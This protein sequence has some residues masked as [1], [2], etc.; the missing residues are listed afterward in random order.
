MEE[1]KKL[2]AVPTPTE[3]KPKIFVYIAKTDKG[4][5]QFQV[6][7]HDIE[8]LGLIEL[9]KFFMTQKMQKEIVMDTKPTAMPT[10]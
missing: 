5:V 9:A 8:A 7:G 3:S 4:E 10:P 1:M 2:E 6:A